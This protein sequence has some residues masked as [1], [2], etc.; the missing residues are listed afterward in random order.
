MDPGDPETHFSRGAYG[1]AQA[2]AAEKSP[3]DQRRLRGEAEDSFRKAIE[4]DPGRPTPHRELG[5]LLYERKRSSRRSLRPVQALH[6][7]RPGRQRRG[8]IRDYV[9]EMSGTGSAG[10]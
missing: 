3:E 8:V 5:L 6:E 10:D 7:A 2:A 9:R 4:L 1:F